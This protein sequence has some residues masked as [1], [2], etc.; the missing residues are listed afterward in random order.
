ME[1][2]KKP[3]RKKK[4]QVPAGIGLLIVLV[5][6]GIVLAG[7]SPMLSIYWIF[8]ISFGFV[9]QKA[10]FCFTAAMRDPVLTGSTSLTRA[11]I[12]ALMLATMGFAAIQYSAVSKGLPIPGNIA[13]AG[14][15]TAIGATM[16]G[17][18]M[19]IAGGC[20]SGTLMRVGEGFVQQ[21]IAL[22]FFII[23]SMW[24]AH[25]Y[26]WW[27]KVFFSKSPAVFLP[28]IFGWAPAFFGQL[29]VLAI[30]FAVAEWYENKKL[31][32]EEE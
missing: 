10:R 14:I 22:V 11:V 25:D 23:G 13:P 6:I 5:V 28:N 32:S 4:N 1:D 2:V 26:G 19:V 3:K 18:G 24:G 29:I 15:F 21:W 27:S 20:A 16:F 8:G 31:G 12:V 9:L 7:I 30:L 17:V